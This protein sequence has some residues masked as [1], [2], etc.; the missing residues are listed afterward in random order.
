MIEQ[1]PT[2]PGVLAR[3]RALRA[4]AGALVIALAACGGKGGGGG[5]PG[6]TPPA[7]GSLEPFA[8]DALGGGGNGNGTG[9]AASFYFPRG[10][11][12]DAA[13]NVYVADT[14]SSTIRKVTPAGVVTTFAGRAGAPG[15]ADGIG[16]AATFDTPQDVATDVGGNVYVADYYNNDIRKIAPDGTVTTLA[17]TPKVSGSADGTG[18]GAAFAHPVGVAADGVGNVYVADTG[19]HTI[20]KI[21]PGGVVTTLAGTAGAP[22][23]AD[24]TGPAARF[25]YPAKLVADGGGNLYVADSGNQTLRMITPAGVV[26]TLAGAAGARGSAD[27][28]GA[29][30]RF[31]NPSG[32]AVDGGGNVYV[33]DT[34]NHTLRK[35]AHGGV[36]TTLAGS[37]AVAGSADG[38]GAAAGFSTPEGVATDAAGNVYVGD[39]D[40]G[41]VRKIT[42]AGEV[43]TLAG[44]PGVIGHADG[45]GPAAS[46]TYPSGLAVDGAGNVYVADVGNHTIRKITAAGVVTTFA[47][48]AG[49]PGHADATG[50]LASFDL[51]QGVATD[52]TGNVYVADRGNRVIRKITP[53]GVVTTLAGTAGV[54]GHADGEGPLASFW[55]P[56]G[57]AADASGNVYVA[58]AGGNNIIRKITP[59]GV[60][61]TL[62]GRVGWGSADGAGAAASF[63]TPWGLAVD[64]A[65][66]V[67]VGDY[68]NAAIRKVTPDGVV[69]TPVGG[70]GRRGFVPGPLPAALGQASGVALSGRTLYATNMNGI[71]RV[72]DLP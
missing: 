26:T 10:V 48:T 34:G 11:A 70:G 55:E 39:M 21:G 20:R 2:L 12:T 1:R 13:G 14:Q 65:G 58:D 38:T 60:V 54:A 4:L 18:A 49:V 27:G 7:G 33:G 16:T 71:V 68:D 36:V 63:N 43:T 42:P 61:T 57:V 67:Y 37:A 8:G 53:A 15:A 41:T 51:P 9:A 25:S 6:P 32:V 28:T 44:T 40:N 17:G 72:V 56:L 62:A 47:G 45:A 52:P 5:S 59:A 19:N 22:G 30:A 69:T 35:V 46:F 23:S 50:A 31:F 24:A 29:A 66:N 3:P 64:G